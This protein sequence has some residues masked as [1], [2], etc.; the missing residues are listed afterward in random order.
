MRRRLSFWCGVCHQCTPCPNHCDSRTC[1]D[2]PGVESRPGSSVDP[3]AYHQARHTARA[4]A[5]QH[6]R[7]FPLPAGRRIAIG[8]ALL[9]RLC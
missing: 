6:C 3:R 7:V 8:E 1:L 4:E 2:V 5:R 9:G